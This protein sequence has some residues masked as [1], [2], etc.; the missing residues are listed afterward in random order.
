[1]KYI[2]GQDREQITIFPVS[3][4]ESIDDDNEVRLIDAFVDGLEI[5][6]FGFKVNHIENLPSRQSGGRPAYHPKDLL[7]LFIYGYMNRIRSS[8]HLE[9]E[10]KRNIELMWLMKT[11]HPDHNT[12]SNFRRD[13]SKSIKLVFRKTVEIAKYFNLIGSILVAGDGTKLRAQNSKKNN[14]NKK[15][16]ARHLEYIDNKVQE[17]Q[18]QLS[19]NDGDKLTSAEKRIIDEQIKKQNSRKK[20]YEE[21]E[22]QIDSSGEYQVSTSDTD[23]RHMITRNNITEVSYNIQATTDAENNIPIDYLVTNTNDSKAMG[24]MLRRAKSILRTNQFTALYDKGYHTGSE[25]KI[26]DSLD[27]KT[28]VAIPAFSGASHA[29]DLAYDVENFVYN[30]EDDTYTCPQGNTLTSNGHWHSAKNR[31]G[32]ISYRFKNYTTKACKNCK[33]K[34]LCTK[35]KVNGKQV[36][37]S[38][39]TENIENNKVRIEQS[40]KL[41]KRRQAIVE[42]PFGTIKRQWGFNHVITKQGMQRASADVGLMFIAYNLRRLINLIGLKTLIKYFK[43]LC[44]IFSKKLAQI[45]I[46][47]SNFKLSE[48]LLKYLHH[49]NKEALKW[50]IFDKI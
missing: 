26:A 44:L 13:N 16:I 37:R 23:S 49:K 21:I 32:K 22:K 40:K 35:S 7:K 43:E 38:E 3:I 14:Y 8:R 6:E 42:H 10:C 50:L 24:K 15:K 18:N 36:R 29:P 33:V 5:E 30:K 25:F 39:Y 11:L 46:E 27:I 28:L 17:Y 34:S 1:M 48:V 2:N 12:I 41:Y 19:D 45:L 47:I 4:D 9:K 20:K 31:V